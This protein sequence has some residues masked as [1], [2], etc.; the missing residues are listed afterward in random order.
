MTN[1]PW[2]AL[3][4]AAGSASKECTCD[5]GDPSWI[6]ESGRSTGEEIGYPFQYSWASPVAQMVKNLPAMWETWV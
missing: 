4:Y 2:P 6:P 3:S 5:A 1:P